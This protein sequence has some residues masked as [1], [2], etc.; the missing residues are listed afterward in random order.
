MSNFINDIKDYAIKEYNTSK[1]LP[2]IIM[3]Q[4][5]LESGW[6]RSKLATEGKN[7]FGIKVGS[8]RGEVITLPT[9]EYINGSWIT[10]NADFRKYN[11]YGESIH[12]HSLLFQL[13]RYKKVLQCTTY[14][15]QAKEIYKGGY[16]TDP[17][18]PS[19]LIQII[20]ENELYQY[21]NAKITPIY[22]YIEKGVAT[23]LVNE[24]NVRNSP[25]TDNTPVATYKKGEKI[26]YDM[27]YKNDGYY[28]ISYISYSGTRRYVASRTTDG[29]TKF[30]Y[31]V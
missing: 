3:A 19:K 13:D 9:Q 16:A 26:N 1:I 5:I 22:S 2:S 24:L 14:R 31:C 11:N 25:N 30:L 10:V 18:Y 20:E 12:D 23:V 27:V 21:D 28:W 29:T 6:G 17:N 15:E 7:L 8:W 4:A